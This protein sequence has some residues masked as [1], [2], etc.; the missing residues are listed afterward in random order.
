MSVD[1]KVA[2]ARPRRLDPDHRPDPASIMAQAREVGIRRPRVRRLA[3][4]GAVPAVVLAVVAGAIIM[5]DRGT[6]PTAHESTRGEPGSTRGEPRSARELLLVA[7]ERSQ[8]GSAT[9]GRY[10][11]QGTEFGSRMEVGPAGNRYHI[12]LRH[13]SE[14]WLATRS[15]DESLAVQQDLGAAPISPADEA[16]WR[17]DGSPARWPIPG[18]DG[19]PSGKFYESAPGP[20][21]IRKMEGATAEN[22]FLLGGSP[23]TLTT[24][25]SLPTDPVALRTWL[26]QRLRAAGNQEGDDY[27]LFWNAKSLVMDLPTTPAVRSAAYRMMADLRGVALLGQVTDQRGRLGMAVAYTHDGDFGPSEFR[28]IIDP[29]TGQAFAEEDR[30]AAGELTRYTLVFDT[31]YRDSEPPVA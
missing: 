19:S 17:A 25:D 23:V 5:S 24:V 6:P 2:D 9:A 22:N 13:S 8:S 4:V 14:M 21:G 11:V 7:A 1:K 3:M 15:G 16:A 31:G 28:L 12:L 26:L 30:N 18:P 20:R 27:A 29:E 10:W